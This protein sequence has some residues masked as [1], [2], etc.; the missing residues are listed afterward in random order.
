MHLLVS[1]QYIDLIMHGATINEILLK[2]RSEF[3]VFVKIYV[4]VS[5]K[6][7]TVDTSKSKKKKMID[8]F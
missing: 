3:Y 2:F 7:Y 5:I 8:C 1:E 6:L 4:A